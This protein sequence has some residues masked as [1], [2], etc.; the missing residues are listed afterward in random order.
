ME[1]SSPLAAI[2]PSMGVWGNPCRYRA[3][4]GSG[5]IS[6]YAAMRPYAANSFRFRDLSMKKSQTDYFGMQPVRGS[7]PTASLAADLSQNCSIDQRY[8]CR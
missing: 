8:G 7:S 6:D 1:T 5:L 4:P 2:Q 3:D